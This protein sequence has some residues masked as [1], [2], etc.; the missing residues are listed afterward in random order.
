MSDPTYDEAWAEAAASNRRNAG[1]L[2]TLELL[3][4]GIVAEGV[5]VPVRAIAARRA[6]QL[7]L[8]D[9]A[10][11]DAGELV[12][13]EP[14]GFTS[15]MPVRAANGAVT[16]KVSISNIG[17][18]IWPYIEKAVEVQADAMLILRQ[19]F[20]SD[21]DTIVVGPVRFV[22]TG[23]T[24]SNGIVEGDCSIDTNADVMVPSLKY[25]ADR[26]NNLNG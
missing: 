3:H 23:V 16:C 2:V 18:R 6:R 13:F 26:F 9:N 20:K 8:E 21:P 4:P 14:L 22:V 5:M 12:T 1:R 7:R 11:V 19:Y 15:S 24:M 25:T 10:P 17:G